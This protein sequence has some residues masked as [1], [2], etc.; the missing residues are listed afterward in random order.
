MALLVPVREGVLRLEPGEQQSL[1]SVLR[2]LRSEAAPISAWTGVA[3][4]LLAAGREA[5]FEALLTEAVERSPDGGS[6]RFGH[7]LALCSLAEFTAQQAAATRDRRRRAELLS[8]STEL[9]NRARRVSG[10]VQEQVTD[11]V[12]GNVMLIR[13]DTN[14]ARKMF[15][16]ASRLRCNGRPSIAAQLALA[17]LSFSQR[18]FAEALKM[19]KQA[20]KACPRCPPQVRLGIAACC[21]KLGNTH[22]AE[23]AYNRVLELAPDCTP[24]L[25]GLAVLKLHIA[26]DEEGV[27]EGSRLLAQAFELD[28]ENPF[29]LLLLAHFCLRQGYADKARQAAK[30]VVEHASF[31]ALQA[32]ALTV[33]GRAYHAGGL[34]NEA[35]QCYQQAHQLDKTLPLPQLGIAQMHV[36]QDN[37][38]NAVSILE[39]VLLEVP[40]WIDALQVIGRVLPRTAQKSTKAVPQLKEAAAQ[41]PKDAEL[42]E[43]LGDVL[44]A[45]EPAG[46]LKA[47]DKAIEI[48]RAAG[49]NGSAA[50]ADGAPRLPSRLLNNAAVMHLRARNSG[51]AYKLTGEALEAS[52]QGLGDLSD[53]AQVTLAYN[54]AR[55]KEDCGD[56]KAAEA[57]YLK[58]LENVP[59]YGDCCLRLACVAKARGDTKEALRW[60]E[61]AVSN[62]AYCNDAL[63]L[64]A[65]L[66]L[67]KR[68]WHNAKQ[69]LDRLLEQ[70]D[71]R[72][73][74]FAKLAMANLHAYTAPSD[75]KK[76]DNVRRAEQR[77]SHAMELYRRVLE[78]DEG[79]ISAAN[80]VGCIL[81]E[82]G[83]MSAAKEVFLQVQEASA[84]TDGFWQMPD[85]SINLGNV[86][87]AQQQYT[88]AIQTYRNTLRKFPDFRSSVVMLYLARAQYDADQ[89]PEAKRTLSKA[90]HLAPTSCDLRFDI[91]V[92]LQE[93]AVRT[94]GRPRPPGD[95]TK[96]SE[97]ARAV[98]DLTAA[99]RLFK[100]LHDLGKASGLDQ[101]K[102]Q[103]H[104]NFIVETHDQ[105]LVHL[106]DAER[107]KVEAEKKQQAA[108]LAAIAEQKQRQLAEQRKAAEEEARK[109][110]LAELAKRG[111]EQLQAAKERWKTNEA[112]AKAVEKGDGAA[113]AKSKAAEERSAIDAN[114]DALF[115]ESEGDEDYAP[116]Q[117]EDE[118]EAMAAAGGGEAGAAALE[119]IDFDDE[120]MEDADAGVGGGGGGGA[121]FEDEGPKRSA[122]GGGGGA[123]Q[124]KRQ[125]AVIS[126]EDEDA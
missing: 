67:D 21:L 86:Y 94:L 98:R 99:H 34:L 72:H 119:D 4:Q 91:G 59:D 11:L 20:L 19:Y 115:E 29:V 124:A 50:G 105:A 37:P 35:G 30:T 26:A 38:Q 82:L 48:R 64:Q 95:P 36:L 49:G 74:S 6:D 27:R 52:S 56:L 25:L 10:Q 120:D 85:A 83:N 117:A 15:E 3:Q 22:K 24:A 110:Q 42:W 7:V 73:E 107:E 84:A 70:A 93:W 90:L 79:C 9:C 106:G 2:V 92:T 104:I 16:A 31:P 103:Q 46:A 33:L 126:D 109:R 54:M 18:N 78:K 88:A 118:L 40:H 14:G 43:L 5:D 71:S 89:L 121:S 23:L 114:V 96:H 45:I 61:Q 65:A 32:E 1:N 60:T 68:D 100:Q 8:R 101:K 80:G 63:A 97:V 76:E 108:A 55:V 102:L 69:V 13:G 87:L 57:E 77:Y 44:S 81:A 66:Y 39:S 112:M 116:G 41:R 28:P 53:V 62:P 17:N 51:A 123:R 58:L 113:A 122:K 47:Y 111:A 75:R 12:F 125:K